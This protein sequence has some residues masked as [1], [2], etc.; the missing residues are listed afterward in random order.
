MKAIPLVIAGLASMISIEV[1]AANIR[2]EGCS[3][4]TMRQLAINSGNGTHTI[5]SLSTNEIRSFSVEMLGA[6]EPA[7]AF[8]KAVNPEQLHEFASLRRVYIETGGTMKFTIEVPVGNIDL[9]AP[10]DLSAWTA[11]DYAANPATHV[12]FQDGVARYANSFAALRHAGTFWQIAGSLTAVTG[13]SI[14]VVLKFAGGG[15]VKFVVEVGQS[16]GQQVGPA[17]D[18]SGN[19]IPGPA[20]NPVNLSGI[21]H[22]ADAIAQQTF[23]AHLSRLGWPVNWQL[24][25]LSSP[26]SFICTW[27]HVRAHL[28]CTMIHPN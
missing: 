9:G 10:I 26:G 4:S 8:P 25:G 7:N 19:S 24:G 18:A 5:F 17:R 3:F 15:R 2:C 21:Y 11:F 23:G 20:E 16:Q 28:I 13:S 6:G 14:E 27:N 12:R 22:F 1:F